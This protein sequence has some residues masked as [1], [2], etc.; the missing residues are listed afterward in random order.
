[1]TKSDQVKQLIPE[2]YKGELSIQDIADK[3]EC[4][5]ATVS[6]VIIRHKL[7]VIEIEKMN[8]KKEN[9]TNFELSIKSLSEANTIKKAKTIG[10][11]STMTEEEKNEY[12]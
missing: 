4:H 1:M 7:K 11:W 12:K 2:F 5:Y 8:F 6:Q 9:E 3:I 10:D